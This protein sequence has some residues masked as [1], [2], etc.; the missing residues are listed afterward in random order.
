MRKNRVAPGGNASLDRAKGL[1]WVFL[2]FSGHRNDK[3]V[4]FKLNTITKRAKKCFRWA[5]PRLVPFWQGLLQHMD[6]LARMG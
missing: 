1:H 4:R 2:V 6:R 3:V 5:R